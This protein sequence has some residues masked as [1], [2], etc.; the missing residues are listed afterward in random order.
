MNAIP[1][2]NG[3][4][5]WDAL[6]NVVG[7]YWKPVIAGG[8]IRDY[9][10]GI[11]PKDIDIFVPAEDDDD[12]VSIID[13]MSPLLAHGRFIWLN[14]D[15]DTGA[16]LMGDV[17][18]TKAKIEYNKAAFSQDLIAVWEGEILGIPVNIIGRRSLENGPQALINE[19]DF[20][21]VKGYYYGDGIVVATGPMEADIVAKTATLAHDR[22]HKQSLQ[23]FERFNMR[24]PNLLRIVDP[25]SV[26]EWSDNFRGDYA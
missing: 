13:Q 3:P 8:A 5:L 14:E 22:T 10:L 26:A 16:I 2:R 6:L 15:A 19:F 24:N 23:R 20:N 4:A 17:D 21:V 12:V 11:E 25:Y 9:Y 7:T 1:N 18:I